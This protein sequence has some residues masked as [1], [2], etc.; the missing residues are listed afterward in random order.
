M[1]EQLDEE[2]QAVVDRV[3]KM[4]RLAGNN[5]NEHERAAAEAKAHEYLAK[6]NLN[7][8]MIEQ[9]GGT[10]NGK[11]ADEN[12]KGGHFEYQRDLWNAV[13][14][15]NFCMYWNQVVRIVE[16]KFMPN[17]KMNGFRKHEIVRHERQHRLV[18]RVHNIILTRTMCEYMEQAVDRL[19][20]E[21]IRGTDEQKRGMW[22]NSFRRGAFENIV[23]RIQERRR[24]LIA[25]DKQKAAKAARTAATAGDP[26]RT[27][28][29]AT[30]VD[31]ERDANNDFIM[32]E[33]GY[34]ARKR[35][36]DAEWR[37]ERAA[38]RAEADAAYTAWCVANPEEAA[39]AA[40][41]VRREE[42]ARQQRQD[43]YWRERGQYTQERTRSDGVKGDRSAHYAGHAAG[44]KISIDAQA[45][46]RKTAG[47]LR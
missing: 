24:E 6:F 15:L 32:G 36:E 4:L 44:E 35:A 2:T 43:R 20:D 1:L 28:T 17:P 22:A 40:A 34:S 30:L 47:R 31:A 16:R 29:L 10:E 3:E 45:S 12:L 5:P 11:R 14:Q 41:E 37:A 42:R 18:G 26:G 27:L 13:A 39:K 19:V 46:T 9:H 23:S 33:D 38:A 25:E 8:A 7:M 21:N